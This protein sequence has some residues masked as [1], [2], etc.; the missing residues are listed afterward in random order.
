MG[1]GQPELGGSQPMA[2]V[3]LVAVKALPTQPCCDSMM[4]CGRA[5][6]C[7]STSCAQ[8]W[9]EALMP[10]GLHWWLGGHRVVW[11]LLSHWGRSASKPTPVLTAS[12]VWPSSGRVVRQWCKGS[13]LCHQ[14][15]KNVKQR[16]FCM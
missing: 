2:G 5:A 7:S 16:S 11:G 12:R 3:G 8:L 4:C 6:H 14:V 9:D 13:S 15:L 1:P 10:S